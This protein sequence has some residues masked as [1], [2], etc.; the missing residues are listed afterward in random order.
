METERIYADHAATTPV[1]NE[2]I[3]TMLPYL[4]TFGFNPSSLHAEGRTARAA[5]DGAR[6]T[7]ASLLGAKAREIVFTGGG[8]EADMLAIAGAARAGRDRGRHIVTSAIEHH[9]VLHATDLLRDEGFE[10][11]VLGVDASGRVDPD[12][13]E[14]ALRPDTVLASIMLA[15][16]ELGTLQPIP[17]L[18]RAARS[19]GVLFHTDAVQAPGRVPIDVE[20]LGVDLLS[21]SAHKFYGPK[22]VGAL[23][24]RSGTPVAPLIVG[25]GQEHGLR[26]GTENV[27][28]IVGFAQALALAVAELPA[29]TARLSTL[30]DRFE[31]ALEA[32]GGAC[33]NGREAERLPNVSSVAF[34]GVDAPTFLVR[35]DLEGV[36][37][38]AGSACAA[39]ATEP[40]HV[41]AALDV[42]SW[43]RTG[44][45][46]FS[47]GRLTSEQDVER[48]V[49][50]LP[51]ILDS[52]RVGDTYLGTDYCGHAS[53]RVEGRF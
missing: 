22:G 47:F 34:R 31:R 10:V 37:A 11:T 1:R 25:G 51:G 45:V 40:S 7:V 12:S 42:P 48:L 24:V 29:E 4:A 43:V 35:L 2:V 8:S 18:A 17:V 13:F 41:L 20:A 53:D 3:A 44:T 5:L 9:A 33:V 32:A 6:T 15:N 23:Y 39:G 27:A 14:A 16:N 28:G 36:A 19:R 26:A 50:M 49:K 46:R 21:L 38:S 52:V 30:R